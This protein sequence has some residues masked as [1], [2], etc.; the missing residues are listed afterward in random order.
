MASICLN[1]IVK[2]EGHIICNTLKN[3]CENIKIDYWVISDTGSTDNTVELIKSFFSEKN[4]PGEIVF[5]Q[6]SNFSENRNFALDACSGKSDYILFFDADDY[7]VGNFQLPELN[8]DA[9]HCQLSSSSNNIRYL[10]KLIIKND[11]S[12]KWKGVL[13]EFLESSKNGKV[14]EISGDYYVVSGRTGNRSQ[15]QEKYLKDAKVLEKAFYDGKDVDL[16]PRYAFYCAQSYRDFGLIDEAIHWYQKRVEMDSGWYD[17]KNYS[18]EQLGLLFEK[19]KNSKEALYYWQCGISSASNRA[20][21]WYH[22]ARWHS[23]NKNFSLAYCLAKQASQIKKPEGNRLFLNNAI[24]TYWCLYEWCLN[25]FRLGK[26]EESYSVFKQLIQ[27][28]PADLVDRLSSNFEKYKP[29]ILKD[30]FL[31]VQRLSDYLQKMNKEFILSKVLDMPL[32]ESEG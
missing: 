17:E 5:H 31:E 27:H 4:I 19:K 20:E 1:M 30:S 21:C 32:I 24:Y 22:L 6:W 28:C 14:G 23:W 26:V 7:F 10:R 11:G 25:A 9:Y 18:Y 13:H 15:D 8:L 2:D 12:Y 16:L 29:Y 3:I